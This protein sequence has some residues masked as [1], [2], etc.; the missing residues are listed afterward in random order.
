M[1]GLILFVRVFAATYFL[2][3]SWGYNKTWHHMT[4]QLFIKSH[5]YYKPILSPFHSLF[6][7][8]LSLSQ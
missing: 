3:E 1:H 5:S 8:S 7:F 6:L 2:V 4:S